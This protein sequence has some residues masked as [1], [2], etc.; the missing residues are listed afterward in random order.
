MLTRN[1]AF[2]PPPRNTTTPLRRLPNMGTHRETSPP[3]HVALPPFF[4]PPPNNTQHYLTSRPH[5]NKRR[6]P[7]VSSPRPPIPL[8]PAPRNPLHS[9]LPPPHPP[10]LRIQPHLPPLSSTFLLAKNDTALSASNTPIHSA[11]GQQLYKVVP[12][13]ADYMGLRP[14]FQRDGG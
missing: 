2:N 11:A 12:D 5:D 7:P 14:P 4:R 3:T 1:T 13:T 10:P 8:L 6:R 9:I